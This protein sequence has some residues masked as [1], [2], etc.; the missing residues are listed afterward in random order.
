MI[1]IRRRPTRVPP[2]CQNRPTWSL[3]EFVGLHFP[4]GPYRDAARKFRNSLEST[5]DL[6][7]SGLHPDDRLH[8]LVS[9]TLDSLEQV[10]L[11]MLLEELLKPR[12]GDELTADV[13]FREAVS[14]MVLAECN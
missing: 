3:E 8:D 12:A 1:G 13:T 10:E 5:F 14:A 11:V 6:D 2:I 7:L 9:V 4:S